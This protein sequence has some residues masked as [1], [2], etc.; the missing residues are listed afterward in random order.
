MKSKSLSVARR[1]VPLALGGVKALAVTSHR[2]GKVRGRREASSRRAPRMAAFLVG[3]GAGAAAEYL[4]DPEQGKRRRHVLRDWTQARLRGGAREAGRKARYAGG[5]AVGVAAEATPPRRDLADLND[6]ALAAK[7]ESELF[8]PEDAPKGTVDV[9]VENR[10][11]YL[12]GEVPSREQLE[13]LVAR[14]GAVDGI[15]RA[16]SLLHLPGEPA[17]TRQ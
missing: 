16:E 13:E 11:V 4:L 12:R 9:N 17:P 6:P 7:V 8:R 1:A 14:A 15:A 3:S 5:K 10:V 2:T